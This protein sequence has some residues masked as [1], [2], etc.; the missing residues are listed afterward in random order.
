MA[1]TSDPLPDLPERARFVLDHCG[2]PMRFRGS[3]TQTR[4]GKLDQSL[5]TSVRATCDRCEATLEL[6]LTE[7]AIAT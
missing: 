4:G 1:V 7:P 6:H 5:T 2:V 3:V